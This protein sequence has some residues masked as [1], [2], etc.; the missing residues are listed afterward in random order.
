MASK[1]TDEHPKIS[2]EE[3]SALKK[4]ADV[5]NDGKLELS[6]IESLVK[7]MKL[8][9]TSIPK[10]I[11]IILKKYDDNGDGHIDSAELKKLYVCLY[12][13]DNISLPVIYNKLNTSCI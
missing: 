8:H 3:Y 9:P 12:Y 6:E 11:Q 1:S 10:E 13:V 5:N 4:F 2:D 7:K